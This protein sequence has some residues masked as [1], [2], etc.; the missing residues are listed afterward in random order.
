MKLQPALIFGEHMVLQRG[1]PI[2]VWGRSVRDDKITVTLG[3][4]SAETA[5]AG[6]LWRVE[7]P[8]MEATERT[9]LSIESALTG[10]RIVFE[11]VAVGEVWL[12]GGQS[13]MEFLLKYD[14]CAGEMYASADDPGLRYF[15][16]P[17]ANFTGCVEMNAYPDDGFWRSWS[18]REN[19]GM[20]SGPSA[21]MGRKLRE[22]LGVPVAFIGCSWGGTPAAAWTAMEDIKANPTL[23]PILKWHEDE[24]GKIDLA[25]YYAL[26]D[27]PVP[28]PTPEERARNDSFMMGEGL[29]EFFKSMADMPPPPLPDYSPFVPGPRACIRPAGLYDNIL[30]KLAPYAVRGAIW[31]QGEDDDARGWYSFYGESMKTLIRS[32]RKLWNKELPFLQVELAPFEGVG[33]TAAK[34]YPAIRRGQRAAMDALPGVHNVCIMDSGDRINIHVRRKKPVGERLALLARRFVY[35]EADLLAESPRFTAAERYGSTVVIRFQNAGDGLVLRGGV[36]DVLQITADG[37]SVSA[38]VS[39]QGDKLILTADVFAGA[40][41]VRIE[42]AEKNFCVDPL[43]NSSG[44]PAFPFTAEV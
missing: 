20:F 27:A 22:A 32:W 35:G 5:A 13:N 43:F 25:Q 44:L 16:Y 6:G 21:Y 28:D 14:E 12:A 39:V 40:K 11:D 42:F 26:S 17:Q 30:C 31:Y 29:E 23:E 33:F 38:G 1:E 7:L 36:E 9:V 10:E 15:R 18:G 3:G 24:C 34:D 41:A 2:P 8:P 19:K 37:E 4:A